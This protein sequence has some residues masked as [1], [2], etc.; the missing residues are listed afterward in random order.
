MSM[1]SCCSFKRKKVIFFTFETWYHHKNY[2][3]L[4]SVIPPPQSSEY[5]NYKYA[6]RGH[7]PLSVVKSYTQSLT[8]LT[9]D[10]VI[11]Y[12]II[13]LNLCNCSVDLTVRFPLEI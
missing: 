8:S 4:K 9:L 10:L 12:S 5:W 6:P 1:F 3:G 7:A 2:K 13:L 11:L